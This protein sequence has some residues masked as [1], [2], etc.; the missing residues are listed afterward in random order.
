MYPYMKK[1]F[2][3]A[4]MAAVAPALLAVPA[5]RDVVRTLEQPDGTTVQ[6]TV[7]GDEFAH[8]Y[9]TLDNLP[10]M[11]N[12]HGF[13]CYAVADENGVVLASD[14]PAR[15]IALRSAADIAFV[16]SINAEAVGQ[17]L[18][19]QKLQRSPMRAAENTS[20]GKGLYHSDYPTLGSPKSL[21]ILAEFSDVK[22]SVDDPADFYDRY[23]HGED[24][25]DY[26]IPGSIDEYFRLSSNGMFTPQFDVYGPVTLPNNQKYYGANDYNGNDSRA[27]ECV[28]DACMGLDS[29][30]NFA[31]YDTDGDGVV[32]NIYV[33]YAGQGESD[34]GPAYSIWPHSWNI[35]YGLGYRP[36]LDNVE[37]SRYGVSNEWAFDAPAGPGTYVHE[38]GHVIG[39]ADHYDVNY[40]TVSTQG[41]TPGYWDI[42]DY[43]S[44]CEDGIC[45]P[46]YTVF[47]RNALKWIDPIIID[48]PMSVELRDVVNSNDGAVI[49]TNN[50]NEFYTLENRQQTSWDR[51]IP[52]HGML[53][54][55]IVYN[56]STWSSNTAN[57]V[58]GSL[59]V[60]LVS[61]S[62]KYSASVES[63]WPTQAFP[64]T[65]NV[66]S[67]TDDTNPSMKT[68]A[69]DP[70][71]LPITNITESNGII[72][73]DVCGGNISLSAPKL[74]SSN[75]NAGGFTIVWEP[76][77][78]AIDYVVSVADA[79]GKV[80]YENEVTGTQFTVDRLNAETTYTANVTARHGDFLSEVT[81]IEVTTGE[82]DF[83][84]AVPEI[85]P[86]TNVTETGFTA[87]WNAVPTA[88]DYLLSVVSVVDKDLQTVT[89]DFGSGNTISLPEGWEFSLGTKS[90]YGSS[91]TGYF[92]QAAPALKF[93][94]HGATLTTAV[95]EDD[96]L[97][98]SCWMRNAGSSTAN[99][100]EITGI[101]TDGNSTLLLK[102][103]PIVSSTSGETVTISNIPTGIHQ[104]VITFF[105]VE[106]GNLALDDVTLTL[107]GTTQAPVITDQPVGNVTSHNITAP[108]GKYLYTVQALNA[109]GAK[110]LVSD[111]ASVGVGTQ[112]CADIEVDP[113]APV[114]YYNLQ[115]IRVA[116]PTAPGIYIRR[117]GS[118]ATKIIR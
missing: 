76:V 94:S 85:L 75:I 6:V 52:G 116:E 36:K 10:L 69:G 90:Y 30:I 19:E 66:T 103:G 96:I 28:Y 9:R 65:M 88:T 91:S 39:L 72:Y 35:E 57:T 79:N 20:A 25:N 68:R 50:E 24:F 18:L 60:Q 95:Y 27:H 33:I 53:I 118:T 70:L 84:L 111:I 55:H 1:F 100:V 7:V 51:A 43:G 73:F 110:S 61:A 22:F 42:M 74:N 49:L 32:D 83:A 99:Y 105:K 107:G 44:Y 112:G 117:Q 21:V 81:S 87:Q 45:P 17:R 108:Q 71:N 40:G 23:F 104:I 86:A 113:N 2:L 67:F 34:Y 62:T 41:L 102:H 101:D 97:T 15:D 63:V 54:Y 12:Q 109:D 92:G 115:G 8:V 98:F 4:A 37:L 31:D 78:G 106:G 46:L 16:S 13:Y 38:F 64:G 29:E 56:E 82:F 80:L 3:A 114:E 5:K 89:A 47:E 26:N 93:N 14:V 77:A 58:K 59:G 11:L 48:G